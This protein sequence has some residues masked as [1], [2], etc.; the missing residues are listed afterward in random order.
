MLL[1]KVI[2]AMCAFRY[3]IVVLSI[4]WIFF[5][6][7]VYDSYLV[8]DFNAS[9]QG[10]NQSIPLILLY[11][12]NHSSKTR[13]NICQGYRNGGHLVNFDHCPFKCEFSCR[14]DDFKRRSPAA[15]LFFGEDFYWPLPLTD[16]NRTS[17]EQRWIFWSWEAPLHHPEYL[18]S[19]LT[20]NWL[21]SLSSSSSR[22]LLIS[23]TMTYRQDSDIVHNYGRYLRRDR[24]STIR[25]HQSVDFYLSPKDNRST[26]DVKKEFRRRENRI[27]WFV[28]NCHTRTQRDRL[29]KQLSDYFPVDQYGLCSSSSSNRS[30][31]STKDF[32]RILFRYKFYLAFENAHCQDYITEK[33]FYNSLAHGSIPIVLG[34]SKEDYTR[35]LPIQSFIYVEHSSDLKA[36]AHELERTS[37]TLRIFEDYHRW[38]SDYRLLAWPSNYYIDDRFCDLCVKLHLD[39]QEKSY[40]NFSHWLNRCE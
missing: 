19:G 14:I 20:F 12:R 2:S 9:Q 25:D 26:F 31:I 15:V 33:V 6:L 29:A 4:G 36:L 32:E 18:K 17:F 10:V 16:R 8:R 30:R 35:A 34:S 22:S 21:V 40:A 3:R 1:K 24:S 28:S 27:A 7:Y 38:R 37:R 23:R 11:T 39:K 13:L 5:N